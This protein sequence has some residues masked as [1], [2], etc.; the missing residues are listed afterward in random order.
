MK[1]SLL[2]SWE[3]PASWELSPAP[4]DPR[5][6]TVVLTVGFK[7][8]GLHSRKAGGYRYL[9]VYLGWCGFQI[10]TEPE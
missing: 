7:D 5:I 4:G 6:V 1:I 3:H 8:F 2:R 9:D 10:D